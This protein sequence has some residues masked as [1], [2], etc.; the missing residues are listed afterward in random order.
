LKTGQLR[1][2]IEFLKPD[3][4][5]PDK[6]RSFFI[7]K[8]FD[9]YLVEEEGDYIL[10]GIENPPGITT[11]VY[12][13]EGTSL[14]LG[15][16]DKTGYITWDEPVD[17]QG[18]AGVAGTDG[19]TGASVVY[20][21][22][23]TD[24]TL[25]IAPSTT[26]TYSSRAS[27]IIWGE[28]V[29]L[30]GEKGE[31]GDKGETG[32]TGEKGETGAKGDK[33]DAGINGVDG[34]NGIDGINGDSFVYEWN[35]TSLRVGAKDSDGNVSWSNY[36]DLK[37]EKGDGADIDVGHF[38]TN[39]TYASDYSLV[40]ENISEIEA[41]IASFDSTIGDIEACVDE[42]LGVGVDVTLN[43]LADNILEE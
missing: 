10:D 7:D 31:K 3:E 21:W 33:G 17:L 32:A 16:K 4:T 6:I 12:K 43:N 18:P 13:W 27:N 36:I 39:E 1:L 19:A 5:Y 29:D 2:N 25:G 42:I 26:S 38:I 34:I 30:K 28:S 35:G 22:E 15:V 11:I 40:K 23:G 37:G 41:K 8:Y 24:L 9:I 14:V 20:K